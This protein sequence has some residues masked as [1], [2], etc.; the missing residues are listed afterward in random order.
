[1]ERVKSKQ[2]LPKRVLAVMLTIA[3]VFGILTG[4]VPGTGITASAADWST[5]VKFED[6]SVGDSITSTST[7]IK[8]DSV[9]S[10]TLEANGYKATGATIPETNPYTFASS[11]NFVLASGTIENQYDPASGNTWYVSAIDSTNRVLTLTGVSSKVSVTGITLTPNT[12]QTMKLGDVVSFDATV[13]PYDATDKKVK[14]STENGYIELYSDNACTKP[15]GT[16]AT[17]V[18]TVYAKAVTA[19]RTTVYATSNDDPTISANCGIV[20]PKEAPKADD[21]VFTAPTDTE[22]E[23]TAKIAGVVPEDTVKGMGDV[24]VH[25]Y[26]DF[27]RKNEIPVADVKAIGNYYVG[28]TVAE[29]TNYKATT[30]V[31]YGDY[32]SFYITA[33]EVKLDW[34]NTSLA[35][36]GQEQCPTATIANAITGEDVDVTVTGGATAVGVYTATA[37]Q[38]TGKDKDNYVLPVNNTQAYSISKNVIKLEVTLDDWTYGDGV[39]PKP[40]ITGLPETDVTVQ[41]KAVGA[42]NGTYTDVRPT[43]A[44]TYNIRGIYNGTDANIEVVSVEDSFT[45]APLE[46]DLEWEDDSTFVYDGDD[47]LPSA[48]VKNLIG[49][50]KCDVTVVGAASN[51]GSHIATATKL[52]NSNYVLPDDADYVYSISKADPA[53]NVYID[54]WDYGDKA[55][56]PVISNNIGGAS[57]TYSY[58]RFDTLIE[59]IAALLDPTHNVYDITT[60]PSDAGYYIIKASAGETINF[61]SGD[62][63]IGFAIFPRTAALE[64]DN[65]S[66][67]YNGEEQIP[68]CEVTNL[69]PGDECTVTVEAGHTD[70]GTYEVEATALSNEN[71]VLPSTT[72]QQFVISKDTPE[73][74]VSMTGWTYGEEANEPDVEGIVGEDDPTFTFYIDEE[75]TEP[76]TAEDGA[77]DEGE[78]PSFAGTYYVKAEVQETANYNEQSSVTEFTIEKKRLE[79]EWSDTEVEYNGEEQIPTVTATNVVEG[80]EVTLELSDAHT[81]AGN[82][83]V[84][85]TFMSGDDNRRNYELPAGLTHA[86]TITPIV[87]ELKWG[88]TKFTYNGADQRPEVSVANLVEGDECGL[89][90]TGATT[91]VGTHTATVLILFNKNYVLPENTSKEFTIAKADLKDAKVCISG[92]REGENPSVPYVE[93]NVEGANVTYK[94][95]PS[96]ASD[97][98][99]TTTV[100]AKAGDYT[101]MAIIDATAGYNGA[102]VTANFT[103]DNKDDYKNEWIDGQWYDEYGTTSYG[104][105]GSWSGKQVAEDRRSLVLL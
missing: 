3:M 98:V 69:V 49:S 88:E 100:P 63:Y 15:V 46:A 7:A 58:A 51:A 66:V 74:V 81:D 60:K 57:I 92:W 12:E 84:K 62:A 18:L 45:I 22:Y 103:V 28:V 77:D 11:D 105:K 17:D 70:A 37:S 26:S 55:C 56:E 102:K 89:F 79:V 42:K 91:S 5:D 53:I 101:V 87:A 94:Y 19:G 24:T 4:A 50:D 48:T 10:I 34:T 9:F 76:T 29:G 99:Y 65:Y 21:F 71:Y 27:D 52:S 44:G 1:M 33:R 43:D 96:G 67:V 13:T 68:T 47:Y 31:V 23:G 95:K 73:F 80:D 25:Y 30:D 40:V 2:A 41:Y 39:I 97:S 75:C 61:N 35:Y 36:N 86:F 104:P 59:C 38:L 54:S 93:G 72:K 83:E 90:V 78:V 14:W 6:L 82:Y 20:I 64:W 85:I 32:W 8:S 16:D